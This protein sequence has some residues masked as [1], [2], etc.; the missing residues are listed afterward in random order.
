MALRC[1]WIGPS[2]RTCRPARRSSYYSLVSPEAGARP[3]LLSAAVRGAWP[4]GGRTLTMTFGCSRSSYITYL[5]REGMQKGWRCVTLNYPGTLGEQ[6][7]VLCPMMT[8]FF[9][10]QLSVVALTYV[11]CMCACQAPRMYSVSS[12]VERLVN[13]VAASF[14]DAPLFALGA[15]L[16]LHLLVKPKTSAQNQMPVVCVCAKAF[17]WAAFS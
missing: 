2:V 13:H 4:G 15:H 11:R 7:T 5:A 6:L 16:S 14:P 17:R 3:T 12:D 1:C 8:T 10:A 9:S